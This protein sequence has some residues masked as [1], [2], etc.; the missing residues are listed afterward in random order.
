M[1]PD[2]ELQGDV[3]DRIRAAAR[4]DG[5]RDC[6]FVWIIIFSSDE[7]VRYKWR[8]EGDGA[9]DRPDERKAGIRKRN[10]SCIKTAQDRQIRSHPMA[11]EEGSSDETSKNNRDWQLSEHLSL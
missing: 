1:A 8:I 4:E 10:I 3:L 7:E 2:I 9:Q 5:E 6:G 11:A